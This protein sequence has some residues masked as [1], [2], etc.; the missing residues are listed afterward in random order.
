MGQYSPPRRHAAQVYRV[1]RAIAATVV[2][3]ILALAWR[4]VGPGGD[5][6]A[7]EATTTSSSTS[8]TL[9]ALPPCSPDADLVVAQDPK[10][11]W[12]TI[13]VDTQRSLPANYGP[14]DLHNISDAGFPLTEGVALRGFVMPDLEALRLAAEANS[15]P[16]KIIVGY[17]SYQTQASLYDRRTDELGASE[18]GSR[19]A[20]PGHSEHQ[21]GTTID[22]TS[23]DLNDVDQ[24]WGATPTGQWIAS[25][26][27]EFGFILSYPSDASERTCYDYEP[28]HL[29]YVGREQ[30]QAVIKER[31]T[32]REF[33]WGLEQQS[34]GT[35]VQGTTTTSAAP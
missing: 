11:D 5:G 24:A 3:L 27:P 17:R 9:P 8:T 33:L 18:A 12:A 16:I 14:P 2:L 20:R 34:A 10:Q 6:G 31:V 23:A 29:R 1:R 15:T 7:A 30:A 4:A 22:I 21:L 25:H 13:L 28:W 19:V 32:L 26:A 35:T